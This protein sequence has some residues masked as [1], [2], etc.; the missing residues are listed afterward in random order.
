MNNIV[1]K[2]IRKY[3][4]LKG[5]S[6]E[7]LAEKMNLTQ[8]AYAKIENNDTKLTIDRLN[9]ISKI[10]E[11][12]IANLLEQKTPN[13]YN[14]YNNEIVNIENKELLKELL[15]TK[16]QLINILQKDSKN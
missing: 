11:I 12:D 8:S 1:S 13:I 16:N 7:Y 9:E 4:N 10:L 15:E 6:Q 3:R 14:I 5:F 2:N